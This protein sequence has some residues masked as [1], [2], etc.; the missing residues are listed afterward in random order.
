VQLQ[1][2]ITTNLKTEW[3]KNPVPMLNVKYQSCPWTKPIIRIAIM[4]WFLHNMYLK[5]LM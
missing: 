2:Q 1:E 5:S 3:T 4:F